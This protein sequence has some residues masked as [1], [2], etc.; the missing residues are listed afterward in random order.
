M[1]LNQAGQDVAAVR[2]DHP[3]VRLTNRG[4]G[5]RDAAIA[6]RHVAIEHVEAVVHRDDDAAANEEG[7]GQASMKDEG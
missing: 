7:H 1:R 5:C 2:I 3:V 6:D 4:T